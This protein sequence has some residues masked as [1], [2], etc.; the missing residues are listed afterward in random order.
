MT[1]CLI[2]D[3]DGTIS[4]PQIGIT[5]CINHAL[6][7]FG[8]DTHDQNDLVRYIG[9]PLD[10]SFSQIIGD[11]DPPTIN[12]L[13]RVYRARYGTI[14]YRE[15]TVYD[16]MAALLQHLKDHDV[17]MGICT[18][19]PEKFARPILE[20]FGLLAYFDFISGGDIGI[21]KAQQLNA[22]LEAGTI[23]RDSIM[24]GDRAVDIS[25]AQHNGLKSAGVLWGFGSRSEIKEAAPDFIFE[26]VSALKHLIF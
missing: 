5:H 12:A 6:E 20:M 17:R 8:Y 15:N 14:G 7:H 21:T 10:Q 22:L 18:S 25:S 13:V 23:N 24:I 11:D 26:D 9:P 1:M 2:F 3:L 16:G 4:D 19:K